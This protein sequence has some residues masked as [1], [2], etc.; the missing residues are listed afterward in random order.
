MVIRER[1]LILGIITVLL[2]MGGVSL[3]LLGR[4]NQSHRT[5]TSLHEGTLRV[6]LDAERLVASSERA[7]RFVRGYLLDPEEEELERLAQARRDFDEGLQRL[8]AEHEAPGFRGLFED[9][10]QLQARVRASATALLE[11]R[12]A[13]APLLAVQEQFERE[14]VPAREELD[15]AIAAMEHAMIASARGDQA[16]AE[17]LLQQNMRL[18]SLS[19]GTSLTAL[20][21]MLALL[22]RSLH[23]QRRRERELRRS[24]AKFAGLVSIAADAIICIDEQQRITIFNRGA[25]SIFGFQA[26]EVLGQ[27]LALLLPESVRALHARHVEAFTTGPDASRHMGASR[28]VHGRRKSGEEFPA[29]AAISK[30]AVEGRSFMTVVLRD[31][32]ERRRA[33]REQRF[34]A[35]AGAVLNES[36]EYQVTLDRVAR[37][38]VPELADCCAIHLV[39][40]GA[41]ALAAV[42]HADAASAEA[43]R[44][45]LKRHPIPLDSQHTLA[46]AVRTGQA[47]LLARLT[48]EASR[49]L[50]RSFEPHLL[51]QQLGCRSLL[52]VPLRVRGRCIG[53][54]SM[55]MGSSDR[56]LG[57]RD[58]ALAEE[59][60]RR[61]ALA[62]DNAWLYAEAQLATRAR[63]EML[64]VVAHDLRSPLNALSLSANLILRRMKKQGADAEQLQS[65]E[66][67]TQT[68]RRMNRL[69]EDLLDVTRMEAGRLLLQR[70]SLPAARLVGDA[71]EAHRILCA[72][73]GLE[74]KVELPAALPEVSADTDRI[75]QVFS[76][77]LGNALKFTPRGGVVTVGA[78]AE[79]GQVVF[80]VSDSGPGIPA[81]HLPHLF[82]RF[83]QARSHDRRGA[84]LGLAIAKGIVEAH[85]GRLQARST[86]GQGSTFSFSLPLPPTGTSPEPATSPAAG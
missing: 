24:E 37:L 50:A 31:T 83:W 32:S 6:V 25:E 1:S 55:M 56:C 44:E 4:I 18:F 74:L 72:E 73:A 51:V 15:S 66:A 57:G 14:H 20:L 28:E 62:I 22:T 13:G 42:A 71:V 64:G 78:T 40:E 21:G 67:I 77:L 34:L 65:I 9:I 58:L 8:K 84:G 63:D 5:I 26:A 85:G 82:D 17:R 81:E 60:A 10:E 53:T 46:Q 48:E 29:E 16:A 75:L 35:A 3:F 47:Q 52:C 79:E 2:L 7:A 86:P 11:A 54:L 12:R 76:N 30:H 39:K 33:E 23:E 41:L 38:V 49:E 68:T 36:L 59:L 80:H 61:A 43:F 70:S 27:P 45:A 69:I 19:L